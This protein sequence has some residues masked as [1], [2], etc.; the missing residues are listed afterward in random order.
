MTRDFSRGWGKAR[1]HRNN[2]CHRPARSG[3]AEFAGT[4]LV[5][6][7]SICMLSRAQWYR[8]QA[9]LALQ[10]GHETRDPTLASTHCRSL[11]KRADRSLLRDAVFPSHAP[12]TRYRQPELT[13]R[14]LMDDTRL[15]LEWNEQRQRLGF[16]SSVSHHA[17]RSASANSVCRAETAVPPKCGN[18]TRARRSRQMPHKFVSA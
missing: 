2:A 9:N 17:S 1:V 18:E 10:R 16:A 4:G 11:Q 14:R 5:L 12:G 8:E 15:P 6:A 7:G 3:Q 13:A